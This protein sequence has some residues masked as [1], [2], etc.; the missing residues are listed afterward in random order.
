MWVPSP[1]ERAEETLT[2]EHPQTEKL[3]IS[4]YP[5]GLS[6][7]QNRSLAKTF[8]FAVQGAW[9]PGRRP[10][11]GGRQAATLPPPQSAQQEAYSARPRALESGPSCAERTLCPHASLGKPTPGFGCCTPHGTGPGGRFSD[12][13]CQERMLTVCTA[14]F[15]PPA[16][17]PAGSG[18]P[19]SLA[20]CSYCCCCVCGLEG[21]GLCFS[22]SGP[23]H[24]HSRDQRAAL[25]PQS[26]DLKQRH[27]KW[28]LERPAL[29]LPQCHSQS[30]SPSSRLP[31][32]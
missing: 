9:G 24:Q 2:A 4:V 28:T 17:L 25:K 29:S 13:L 20:G 11:R 5:S 22:L 23:I 27:G 15:L 12:P 32:R 1:P 31:G 19:A 21:G 30:T 3:E 16:R 7:R 6:P 26:C 10:V 18:L 14:P 8:A